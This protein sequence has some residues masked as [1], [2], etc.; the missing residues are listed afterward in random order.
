M[1]GDWS[2]TLDFTRDGISGEPCPLSAGVLGS[3]VD[4]MGLVDGWRGKNAGV[5]QYAWI[6][7]S[8]DRVHAARLDG[9]YILRS[10]WNRLSVAHIHP[11]TFSDHRS[12]TMDVSLAL[13]RCKSAYWHFNVKLLQDRNCCL[14]LREWIHGVWR[15][16]SSISGGSAPN[17]GRGDS[18]ITL[19]EGTVAVQQL[20]TGR[21]L[22]VDGL[23]ADFC[24]HFWELIGRDFAEVLRK[25]IGVGSLSQSCRPAATALLPKKGD[26]CLL[27]NWRPVAL[28]CTDYGILSKVLSNRL[29]K[30]MGSVG[31]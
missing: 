31:D 16:S 18:D 25:W 8:E 7:A 30:H 11:S 3:I 2:C 13:T 10:A 26:L 29:N 23:S 24:E 12:V 21:A 5:I 22:A 17:G 28:L 15:M 4:S 20:S 27:A 9:L 6:K 14:M 19:Q 1:E